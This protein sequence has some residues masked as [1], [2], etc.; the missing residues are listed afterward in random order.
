MLDQT[1]A[2]NTEATSK[3]GT[4]EG[5]S[6]GLFRPVGVLYTLLYYQ[7]SMLIEENDQSVPLSQGILFAVDSSPI[8]FY[9]K[10]IWAGGGLFKRGRYQ[11]KVVHSL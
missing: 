9:G 1:F 6:R 2:N 10:Q 4:D 5:T 7:A 11:K 3:S 8:N